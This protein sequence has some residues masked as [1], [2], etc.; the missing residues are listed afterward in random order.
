MHESDKKEMADRILKVSRMLLA[1]LSPKE[2][3]QEIC[4]NVSLKWDVSERQVQRYI[5]RCY[6]SWHKDFQKKRE[7]NI[8]YHLAKRRDLYKQAYDKKDWKECLEIAKDESK[9][10]DIYPAEKHKVGFEEI[11]VI[12]PKEEKE[13]DS[14]SGQNDN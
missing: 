6:T 8:Y 5:R 12:G 13:E 10:M 9:I 1:G 14:K 2:I 11:I 7:A 4:Q 3:Y